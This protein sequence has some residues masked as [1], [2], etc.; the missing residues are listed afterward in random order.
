MPFCDRYLETLS[1]FSDLKLNE[2]KKLSEFKKSTMN[3]LDSKG[4]YTAYP[5]L[6]CNTMTAQYEHTLYLSENKKIVFSESTDY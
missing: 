2:P 3:L 4:L 6:Y 5:P 1:V